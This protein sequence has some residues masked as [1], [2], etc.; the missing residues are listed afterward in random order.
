M[1]AISRELL[2]PLRSCCKRFSEKKRT[3]AAWCTASPAFRSALRSNWKSFSRWGNRAA[4]N[5]D[6][7]A[8]KCNSCFSTISDKL[9]G[10]F[11]A[12]TVA[13][14]TMKVAQISKPGAGFQIVEREIPEP[15]AG[16]VRIKVQACGVCHSDV[17][18]KEGLRPGIQYPRVPGHEVAG[19]I[20]EVGAGVSAW[21]KG[22]RVGVGWHGGQDNTCRECRRGDFRNCRNLKIPGISYDGGYQQYMVAP[23]EALVPIPETLTDTEAAPLLCAG[24]TTYNA[25]RHSGAFPGDLVAVQGIGG[26][27]HLG[28][29][30]A[31]KFGYNVVAIGRGSETAVLAKKLGA[32]VYIDSG[33]TNPAEAL[34]KLGGAQVI[35]T[36]APSSQ[37]K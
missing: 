27:G 9:K 8:R 13:V 11:M 5:V 22:Q 26:L 21:N 6:R 4:S 1:S 24:I 15:G 29:Q 14:A 17:L 33:S 30:F 28:I 37:A 10:G 2:T 3:L 18:T 19:I 31:N 35:L 25:L 20:D 12:T 32:S 16:H 7:S 23:I 34:Q 36:T